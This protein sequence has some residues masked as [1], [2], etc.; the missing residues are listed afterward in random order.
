MRN[1]V[2]VSP[3]YFKGIIYLFINI[4]FLDIVY[5]ETLI[6]IYFDEFYVFIDYFLFILLTVPDL[7]GEG[8]VGI[9]SS[10]AVDKRVL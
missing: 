7:G 9:L 6:I 5:I 3:L 2:Y 10:G 8:Q 1:Y 4:I